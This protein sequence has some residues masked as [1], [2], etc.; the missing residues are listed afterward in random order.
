MCHTRNVTQNNLKGPTYNHIRSL[1][2]EILMFVC[3]QVARSREIFMFVCN[4]VAKSREILMFVCLPKT[5]NAVMSQSSV[6]SLC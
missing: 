2:S 4:H 5:N 1:K 3:N 6:V